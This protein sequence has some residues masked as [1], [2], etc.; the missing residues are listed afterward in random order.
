MATIEQAIDVDVPVRTAYNQW[1][2]FE[3]FPEFMEGVEEIRQT[4]DTHRTGWQ[5]VGGT[6]TS[7]TPR[8]PSSIPT[9]ASPGRARAA[10]HA[11]VV[12]FHRLDDNPPE[13]MVQMDVDPDGSS[14]AG[15]V[16]SWGS[17]SAGSRATWSGS[18]S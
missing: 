5:G 11:G 13:V 15:R 2:Q 8:S 1:T 16:T 14:R 12:T 7:S 18:R 4:D 10:A 6:A 3:S 17:S 9:S